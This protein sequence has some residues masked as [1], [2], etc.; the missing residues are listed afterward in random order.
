MFST[1]P[2]SCCL[3]DCKMM[4]VMRRNVIPMNPCIYTCSVVP[5]WLLELQGPL[6]RKVLEDL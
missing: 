5:I 2:S 1:I 4:L 6:I 3:N